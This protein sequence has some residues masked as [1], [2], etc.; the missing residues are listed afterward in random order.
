M[1]LTMSVISK[2]KRKAKIRRSRRRMKYKAIVSMTQ[3]HSEYYC[4]MI[5]KYLL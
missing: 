3:K 4:R 5:T 1:E 2:I